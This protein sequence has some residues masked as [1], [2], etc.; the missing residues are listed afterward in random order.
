MTAPTVDDVRA[1]LSDTTLTT[2]VLETYIA[3]ATTMTTAVL[4]GAGLSE[5][6]LFEITRWLTAHMITVTRERL[7]KTEGAGGASISYIGEYGRNLSGSPYGQM[8]LLLDRSNRMASLGKRNASVFAIT[9]F[10]S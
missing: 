8:V 7:A 1:I 3:S 2:E 5:F 4:D 9:S 6:F 10:D